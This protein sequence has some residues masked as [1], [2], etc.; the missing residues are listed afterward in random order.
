MTVRGILVFGLVLMMNFLSAQTLNY[1][2]GNLHSHSGYS[3]GNQD[4]SSTGVSKPLPDYA[5]AK[6]SQHFDFLGISEHNHYSSNH[7]PGMLRYKYSQGLAQ[8]AAADQPGTFL[9]LY[10]MEWGTISN[11]GHVVIYGF[12]QLIGWETNVGGITGPNYDIFNAKTDYNGLFKLVKSNPNAFATLAHPN[13]T[14]YSGLTSSSYSPANDSAIVGVAFRNG[15]A[16]T[17]NANYNS[18]PLSDFFAYYRI[19]LNRGYHIGMNYDH[20]NHNLNFGR[21]NAGRL[22]IMAPALTQADLFY[23]M[24]NM[25]FYGSDDWNCKIDFKIGSGIMGDSI[26]GTVAPSISVIHNDDD[27]EMA[28]SIKLWSGK[29]GSHGDPTIISMIKGSNTLFF[30]DN[31]IITDDTTKYYLAEIVQTDGQRI[32]TSPIWYTKRSFVGVKEYK[33]DLNFIMFPNPVNNRLNVST[34]YNGKYCI[35]IWDVSGKTIFKE[36][37]S[38]PDATINTSEFAKGFYSIKISSESFTRTKKLV[39]E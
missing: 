22:V 21:G 18:Y 31:S 13:Y 14:D 9:A 6:L 10:G 19:L 12:N 25:H 28:D 26:S 5:Y 35:E 16:T 24:K 8:A 20:D 3:D 4:S 15:L 2:F 38:L 7:N 36:N 33:E 1:Y 39:I 34:G 37:Y 27:G 17:P 23:A 32:V 30:T 29:V 11:G